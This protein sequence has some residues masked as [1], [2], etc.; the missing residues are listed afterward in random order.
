MEI[1]FWKKDTQKHKRGGKIIA[2]NSDIGTS[3]CFS[4][5]IKNAVFLRQNILEI[6]IKIQILNAGIIHSQ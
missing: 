4:K 1:F 5:C 2:E 6:S 3:Q